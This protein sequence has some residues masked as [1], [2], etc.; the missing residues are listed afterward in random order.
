MKALFYALVA[1]CA[2]EELSLTA[3]S[4]FDYNFHYVF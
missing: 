1:I 3:C 2:V 4:V